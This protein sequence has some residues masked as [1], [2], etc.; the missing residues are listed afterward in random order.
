[1]VDNEP[2]KTKTN[3]KKVPS[4]LNKQEKTVL[5]LSKVLFGLSFFLPTI[6]T[7]RNDEAS[8]Y[9]GIKAAYLSVLF[10]LY[11]F[12]CFL[13]NPL[14]FIGISLAYFKKF[15]ASSIVLIIGLLFAFS[16]F[17]VIGLEFPANEGGVGPPIVPKKFEYGYYIWLISMALPAILAFLRSRKKQ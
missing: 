16:S 13:A 6:T 1:M 4:G 3:Q 12:P 11:G 8:T 2:N 9:L 5:I 17:F 15:V 10:I 14:F 7:Y